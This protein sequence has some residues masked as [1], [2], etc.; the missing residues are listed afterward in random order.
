ML[1]NYTVTDLGIPNERSFF[2]I[3]ELKGKSS[4]SSPAKQN[5][6]NALPSTGVSSMRSLGFVA[7]AGSSVSRGRQKL[8]G[9]S[10]LSSLARQ[11][12]QKLLP[13]V[14]MSRMRTRKTPLNSS[15]RSLSFFVAGAFKSTS[16]NSETVELEKPRLWSVM[17]KHARQG[18][19]IHGATFRSLCQKNFPVINRSALFMRVRGALRVH[20]IERLRLEL[21]AIVD[22]FGEIKADARSRKDLK[23]T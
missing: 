16:E 15:V 19:L 13:N 1:I 11:D 10:P 9:E 4:V 18:H 23:P 22:V 5:S 3:D 21:G 17:K 2:K 8:H 12:S 6:Q 20:G 14:G 7:A